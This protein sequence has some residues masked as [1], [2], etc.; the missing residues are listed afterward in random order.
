VGVCAKEGKFQLP[1][2][3]IDEV[4]ILQKEYRKC[5]WNYLKEK[6]IEMKHKQERKI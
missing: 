1:K 6:L 3:E 4:H 2:M 5:H